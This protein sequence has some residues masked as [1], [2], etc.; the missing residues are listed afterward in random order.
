MGFI[1]S[2]NDHM[3]YKIYFSEVASNL[4]MMMLEFIQQHYS[5][6][7]MWQLICNAT[8]WLP[9]NF[10]VTLDFRILSMHTSAQ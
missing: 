10:V 9:A 4:L 5:A 3:V 1:F 2:K 6:V 7:L 8:M